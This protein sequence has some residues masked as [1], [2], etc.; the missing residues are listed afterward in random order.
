MKC[1]RERPNTRESAGRDRHCSPKVT[2]ALVV[3]ESV[4]PVVQ[5]LAQIHLLGGPEGGL[6]ALVGLP[7]LQGR[8]G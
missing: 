8:L 7:D 4:L 6:G 5:I 2:Y 3:V 1:Y